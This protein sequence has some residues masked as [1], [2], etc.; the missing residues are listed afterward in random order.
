MPTTR[1]RF[2]SVGAEILGGTPAQLDVNLKQELAMWTRV[3]KAANIKV[4]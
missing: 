4:D 1:D 3:V 2:S